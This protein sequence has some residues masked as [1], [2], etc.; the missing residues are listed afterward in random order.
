MEKREPQTAVS[1]ED[2]VTLLIL[3]K[4]LRDPELYRQYAEVR[5]QRHQPFPPN[6][7]IGLAGHHWLQENR[8]LTG[9]ADEGS[10]IVAQ[11]S[12]TQLRWY[13]SNDLATD[14]KPLYGDGLMTHWEYK[15]HIPLP[16]LT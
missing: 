6:Q 4:D 2:D 13:H 1:D 15:G 16:D 9:S 11:W 3:G 12:P 7:H 10:W 5:K 8:R 14:A